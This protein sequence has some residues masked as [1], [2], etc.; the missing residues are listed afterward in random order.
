MVAQ[1]SIERFYNLIESYISAARESGFVCPCSAELFCKNKKSN[2]SKLTL[3][4]LSLFAGAVESQG[5]PVGVRIKWQCGN[6]LLE[7][8]LQ[9]GSDIGGYR[10]INEQGVSKAGDLS[11][12]NISDVCKWVL[13]DWS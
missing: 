9:E 4:K 6:L 7:M 11:P 13:N 1:K 3:R 5:C 8:I 2:V 10:C 12:S